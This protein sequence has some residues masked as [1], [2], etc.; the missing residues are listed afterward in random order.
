MELTITGNVG[1]KNVTGFET[2]LGRHVGIMNV[3][4]LTN[5][6]DFGAVLNPCS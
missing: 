2:K 3:Q 5:S 4:S 1:A 6:G